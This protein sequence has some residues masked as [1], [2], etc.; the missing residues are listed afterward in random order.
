MIGPVKSPALSAAVEKEAAIHGDI[1]RVRM[2]YTYSGLRE[3]VATLRQ[4]IVTLAHGLQSLLASLD[5]MEI[6]H[7]R[8]TDLLLPDVS[9]F[10]TKPVQNVLPFINQSNASPLSQLAGDGHVLNVQQRLGQ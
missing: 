1:C 5:K 10:D 9:T 7:H 3:K 6:N 2:E 8:P 4:F